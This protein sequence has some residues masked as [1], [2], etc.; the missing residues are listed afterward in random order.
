MWADG[1]GTL[2]TQRRVRLRPVPYALCSKA[3]LEERLSTT[4]LR[5]KGKV[6]EYL[7]GGLILSVIPVVERDRL[8]GSGSVTPRGIRVQTD[9]EWA[10]ASSLAYWLENYDL[11]LPDEFLEH[12][13]SK[14]WRIPRGL[15]SENLLIF[16]ED[17]HV[18]ANDDAC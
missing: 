6:I 2:A 10:W 9:G 12:V 8:S 11:S 7:K 16:P 14:S 17:M 1:G 15:R 13:R 18:L 5:D 3:W 4:P